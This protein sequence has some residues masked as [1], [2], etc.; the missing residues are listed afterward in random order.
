MPR[1]D[2]GHGAHV[3]VQEPGVVHVPAQQ[4]PSRQPE[5]KLHGPPP[6]CLSVQ[7]P[8]VQNSTAEH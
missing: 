2:S 3:A 4:Q 8:P 7:T 6:G 1:W 5:L